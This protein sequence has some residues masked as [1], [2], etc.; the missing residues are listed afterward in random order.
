ML[1]IKIIA[2]LLAAL[3]ISKSYLDFRKKREPKIMFLF[4]TVVWVIAS[5]ITIYPAL[6]D[7]IA[8]YSRDQS[9]TFGSMVSL[10]F[11]FMLFIVYR[12]YAKVAR[13]EYQQAELIRKLGLKKVIKK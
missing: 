2:V 1:I 3:S 9:I 10:A 7:K 5:T 13:I 12:V 11:L 8:A 6:I 4:W